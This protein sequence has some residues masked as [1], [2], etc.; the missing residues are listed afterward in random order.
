MSIQQLENLLTK[1]SSTAHWWQENQHQIK[2]VRRKQSWKGALTIFAML[3][4]LVIGFKLTVYLTTL[5]VPIESLWGFGGVILGSGCIAVI[6]ETIEYF[7]K[8]RLKKWPRGFTP[9]CEELTADMFC[10]STTID[11]KQKRTI[12]QRIANHPDPAVRQYINNLSILQDLELPNAWW[13]AVEN[14]LENI[15][16]LNPTQAAKSDQQQ[17]AEVF[18]EIEQKSEQHRAPK[19]LKV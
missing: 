10:S 14:A 8:K 11:L 12:L 15:P 1:A 17:L 18:V 9:P 13:R 5:L 2:K 3:A 6:G 19:I 16:N 4:T 7:Y